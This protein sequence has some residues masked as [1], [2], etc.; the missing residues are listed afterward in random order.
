MWTESSLRNLITVAVVVLGVTA[1]SDS[2]ADTKV[3]P[4]ILCVRNGRSTPPAIEL[5]YT[6]VGV[7][8]FTASNK[9]IICPVVRDNEASTMDVTDWDITVNRMGNMSAWTVRLASS[10]ADGSTSFA[11]T[12]TVPAVDG[13]QELDGTAIT[14]AFEG[15][16]MFLTSTMPPSVRLARY[17]ITESD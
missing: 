6:T 10:S 16:I 11:S 7:S 13:V 5:N 12:I 1:A 15:G 2:R 9:T 4:G 17:Q 8:N 3:F 14:S